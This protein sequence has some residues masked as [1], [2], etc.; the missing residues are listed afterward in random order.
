M[1]FYIL[2]F[3][4]DLIHW[5]AAVDSNPR[6]SS[7]SMQF[8]LEPLYPRGETVRKPCVQGCKMPIVFKADI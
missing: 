8:K 7:P 5:Q 6:S 1:Y 4:G 3:S 2:H